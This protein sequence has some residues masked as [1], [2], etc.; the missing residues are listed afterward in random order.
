MR[1]LTEEETSL[2]F[3]KLASFIG[4][5]VS[6]LIDRNDGDYCFRNHK[7]RV[8][9]C[10]EN[11]MRQAACISREPLLSFGTCLGKFTKSKKF[12]LQITALDY[13]APYAKFKVWLKPNAEQQFLY[14]NNILKSGIARMTD[15]T[16][17]HAGIV[18]YSMTDVPLGFGVSAKG[19]SDSKRA[20]PTALV[21]LH[22]CDLGEYL[23]NES[24]L[25]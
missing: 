23:R 6:M 9:Y 24:H 13:L 21:V 1:P 16:P 15:G 7:E 4:D 11:L 14:G 8:Y 5:N 25:N 12:H 3:A 19:T 18:V 20:D 2:V 10:S 17:T 22:Q